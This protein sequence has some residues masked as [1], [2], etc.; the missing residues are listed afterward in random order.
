MLFN[1]YIRLLLT[2]YIGDGLS[3]NGK[4]ISDY[5]EIIVLGRIK[6]ETWIKYLAS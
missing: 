6:L 4:Q 1:E 5:F 2:K 3:G